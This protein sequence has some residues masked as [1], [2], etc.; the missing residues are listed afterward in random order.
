MVKH[1]VVLKALLMYFNK[2]LYGRAESHDLSDFFA[3]QIYLYVKT[4]RP[5]C[6][7]VK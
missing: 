1:L 6:I 7:T 5:Y 3:K 2:V 4:V